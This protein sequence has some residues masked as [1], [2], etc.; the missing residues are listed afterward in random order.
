MQEARQ[1]LC[2]EGVMEDLSVSDMWNLSSKCELSFLTDLVNI[3]I[4]GS[5]G[6]IDLS[7]SEID[8]I[9]EFLVLAKEKMK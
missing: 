8:R 2:E 9:I 5:E 4:T 6:S 7:R 1:A 3:K